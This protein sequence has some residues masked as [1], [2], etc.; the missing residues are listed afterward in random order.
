MGAREPASFD[1]LV[2]PF[3]GSREPRIFEI[4]RRCMDRDGKVVD[5]LNDILPAGRVLDVGAGDG[6]TAERLSRPDR[7]VVALEPDPGM[8]ATRRR[9]IWAS[10][11]A[12][13]IPF[14]DGSFDAAY[15]TWAFF[16]SGVEPRRQETGLTEVERVVVPGGPIVV[17]DNA[18]D[19]EFCALSDR[20]LADDGA[21]WTERGFERH[22]LEAPSNSTRWRRRANSWPSISGRARPAASRPRPSR[23]E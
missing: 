11:V 5:F 1:G 19:D 20:P 18:G 9:L 15:A 14:H 23:S 12:E 17:V 3:Y 8:V 2:I 21:W 6:F 16:L 13:S 22:V 4:E 7:V 10:G